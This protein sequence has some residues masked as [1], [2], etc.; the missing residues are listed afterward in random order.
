MLSQIIQLYGKGFSVDARV[1]YTPIIHA[2]VIVSM[3]TL[4]KQAKALDGKFETMYS[5]KVEASASYIEAE[6]KHD[7]LVNPMIAGHM[8]D[9]W[10]DPGIRKTFDLRAR[11]QL[12][13][14]CA[15]FFDQ[16]EEVGKAA[17]I[18]SYNDVLRCRARTTGIVETQFVLEGNRFRLLDVGGQRNERKKWFHCFEEVTAVIFVVALSEYDQLLFEDNATNRMFEALDLFNEICNS[19]SVRPHLHSVCTCLLTLFAVPA[20]LVQVVPQDLDDPVPE[21]ERPVPGEDRARGAEGVVPRV[22]RRRGRL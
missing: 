8:R 11:F 5:D 4:I 20:C 19:R 3:K 9:L 21:Q 1:P 12:T 13:D 2:N 17:Y 14:S 15:W 10:A 7:S 22:R 18:P 6:V 16:I